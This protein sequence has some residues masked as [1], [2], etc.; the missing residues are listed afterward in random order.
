MAERDSGG[1]EVITSVVPY[2]NVCALVGYYFAVF[3]ILGVIPIIGLFFT[4]LGVVAFVLGILGL[5]AAA[6]TPEVKGKVHAWFA[7]LVGGFFALVTGIGNLMLL[8]TMLMR[9]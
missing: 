9:N 2:K 6:Q 7:I 1:N 4:L 3:S 5:R 8:S